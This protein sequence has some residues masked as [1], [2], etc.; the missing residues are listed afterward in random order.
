MASDNELFCL[1]FDDE[2]NQYVIIFKLHMDVF[3]TE[4]DVIDQWTDL[5]FKQFIIPMKTLAD[6][7][8]IVNIGVLIVSYITRC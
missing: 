2:I 8:L 3:T 1:C 4:V 5:N 7:K 6:I